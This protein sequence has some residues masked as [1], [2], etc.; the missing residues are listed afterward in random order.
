MPTD[1][2]VRL[3]DFTPDTRIESAQVDAEHDLFVATL[4][5]K[6]G[7][8]TTESIT[9]VKTFTQATTFNNALGVVASTITERSPSV[10]VTV[11]SLLIKDG[12]TAEPKMI[13]GCVV[14]W[15]SVA[16]VSIATGAATA[17]SNTDNIL[18]ASTL[19]VSLAASGANGLDTGVEA[20]NTWYYVW[21]CKGASGVCG[22][23][24]ASRTAP[25]L[26]TGYAV[27]KRL[28]PIAVRNDASS[29]LAVFFV[30]IGWPTRPQILFEEPAQ[31]SLQAAS[32][33]ISSSFTANSLVKG[34]PPISKLCQVM[35]T[36]TAAANISARPTGS[37]ATI[38]RVVDVNTTGFDILD[39]AT[40]ANQSADFA[41]NSGTASV[42][43][44]G[45]VV[46]EL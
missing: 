16:S 43:V 3:Y 17:D 31:S 1:D 9:G 25:T 8:A 20:I 45:Y 40:D 46:T 27:S 38:G 22:I 19:T 23:L 34:V 7:R 12:Y 30:G 24:S 11:D 28:L 37:S 13:T 15:A 39:V 10:G 41:V 4:N 29:N 18:V 5:G 42:Y 21:L 2:I 36:C 33:V 6:V 35:V 26:P 14:S 44:A 32:N